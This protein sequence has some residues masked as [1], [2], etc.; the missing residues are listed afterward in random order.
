MFE[1]RH[2]D[3]AWELGVLFA[4]GFIDGCFTVIGIPD[5]LQE[6]FN[7]GRSDAGNLSEERI[8]KFANEWD[9]VWEGA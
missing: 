8:E 7:A 6:I 9:V 5:H 2:A 4:A 1:V 3:D